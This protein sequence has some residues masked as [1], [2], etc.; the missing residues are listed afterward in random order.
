MLTPYEIMHDPTASQWLKDSLRAALQRDPVDAAN[1]AEW[2][3]DY[4]KTKLD[5]IVE[6]S[7]RAGIAAAL[8]LSVAIPP[9]QFPDIVSAGQT[10]APECVF[11]C[12]ARS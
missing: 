11:Y 5:H 4:M 8:L 7:R 1:D 2:L 10:N 6:A 12:E 9:V 3:A